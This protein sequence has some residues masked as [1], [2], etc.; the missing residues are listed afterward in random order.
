M[1]EKGSERGSDG[2]RG[3]EITNQLMNSKP[4]HYGFRTAEDR[5]TTYF[6]TNFP[7]DATVV[8]I[9][10]LL[11]RYWKLGEVYI[12]AKRD[13]YS[14]RFGFARFVDVENSQKL[15]KKIEETWM[16]TYKIRAN[17]SKFKRGD[18]AV[19]RLNN[20]TGDQKQ[21]RSL[22]KEGL[23]EGMTFKAVLGVGEVC[24]VGKPKG[25]GK[26]RGINYLDN[27]LK[28]E[29]V[30]AN[31]E[32]LSHSYVATLWEPNMAE[33]IQMMIHMA[34]FQDVTAT[35]MGIDK[36]LLSS[37]KEDGVK[38]AVDADSRWWKR[39]FSDIKPWSTIQKPRGRR[40]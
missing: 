19:G 35:L 27:V 17:L 6:I 12:P 1:R 25:Y 10:E 38:K 29:A 15:L 22:P 26:N 40:I 39:L 16:G 32:K 13:K 21:N 4:E 3:P 33:S 24:S 14:K 9:W 31:L 30:P 2:G 8:E 11:A 7:E 28:V 18:G 5:T 20:Q 37:I 23:H 34:G 36:I